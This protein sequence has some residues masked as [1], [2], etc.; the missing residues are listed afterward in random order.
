MNCYIAAF[1]NGKNEAYL[2]RKCELSYSNI[3]PQCVEKDSC[4]EGCYC[5]PGYA[6]DYNGECVKLNEIPRKSENKNETINTLKQK[7][8]IFI[9]FVK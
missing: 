4:T 6:R 3:D 8:L 1:C 7:L 9:K 2:C 5:L